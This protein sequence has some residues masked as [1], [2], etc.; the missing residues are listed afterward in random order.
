[1]STSKKKIVVVGGGTGTHTV[2]KGLKKYA[3]SLDIAAIVTMADSGGSTGRLRD[4]FG[5][6]PVGDVRMALTALAA[7]VDAHDELLRELF[8]YRFHKGEGLTGHTFGNLLLTALTEILGSEVAA[9]EAA[10]RILQVHGRVFPVSTDNIHLQAEYDDG[11]VVIGEH[12][13]DDPSPL[14]RKRRINKLSLVPEGSINPAAAQSLREADL[15]VFGPGDLYTSILANT[16]VSG[17]TEALAASRARVVYVCNLMTRPGQTIGMTASDHIAELV[18]YT[19]RTPNLILL[20]NTTL[21]EELIARYQIEEGAHPVSFSCL[22]GECT[23]DAS[24]LLATEE[25]QTVRGDMVRRSLIRHD[26][27]KL[28]AAIVRQL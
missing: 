14:Y 28:A 3:D 1:M 23:I 5:Q 6:L 9:I 27:H 17:F 11:V 26:P 18:R 19:G 24:D 2:L 8:L 10:S 13:I 15:I 20:N 16:I 4:E 22:S 25:V 21:P 7:D 12:H